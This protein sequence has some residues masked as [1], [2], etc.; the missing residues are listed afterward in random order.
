M[1]YVACPSR[2]ATGGVEFLHQVCAELNKYTRTM[3]W[4]PEGGYKPQMPEYDVYDNRYTFTTPNPEDM[5]IVPEIWVNMVYALDSRF[6]ILW[7]SVDNLFSYNGISEITI[8]KGVLHL[9]QS[10]YAKQFVLS[11]YADEVIELSD[12]INDDFF[13]SYEEKERYDYVLCNPAKGMEFTRLLADAMPETIFVTLQGLPRKRLINLMRMSKLYIDFGNHPGKD[14]MPREA[15]MCGCCIITG[16]NGSAAYRE[17]VRIPD[18]YKI[19]R[20][21]KNIS[22]ICHRIQEALDLYPVDDFEEYRE[23]IR[24]EKARFQE[25]IKKLAEVIQ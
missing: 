6:A 19:D 9:T 17:D 7:E 3:I 5:V 1:I 2:Y 4:Y 10:E 23:A 14:R 22:K 15:A 20:L 13:E 16:R 25:G 11:N 12:Y 24:G 8:P 18:A 21:E